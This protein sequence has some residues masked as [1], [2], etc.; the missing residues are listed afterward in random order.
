MIPQPSFYLV[1]RFLLLVLLC[2]LLSC[3]SG[4]ESTKTV[5]PL[6]DPTSVPHPPLWLIYD[7]PVESVD[8]TMDTDK[9]VTGKQASIFERREKGKAWADALSE[10]FVT[11]LSKAGITSR[12]ATDS[13]HIP[14]HAVVI[15]GKF[16]SINEG[17]RIKRSTI[18]FGAGAEEI[19]VMVRVYQKR[20]EALIRL[21]AIEAQ[22]H[23]SKAPGV[24]GLVLSAGQEAKRDEGM[25]TTVEH[26]AKKL[27][28][29]GIRYYKKRGWL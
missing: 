22:A 8:V 18:G 25:Q 20:E 23:G 21:T 15:K 10:A 6:K 27:V 9:L 17:D 11:Q 12:R 5:R 24:A 13:T 16:L 4:G 1:I 19:S 3:G 26:L 29:R 7:F 2:F 28:E 14:Q